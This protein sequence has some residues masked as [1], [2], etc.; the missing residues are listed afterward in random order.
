MS[1][2]SWGDPT[3]CKNP[4]AMSKL[5]QFFVVVVVVALFYGVSHELYTFTFV[6][7]NCFAV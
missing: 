6:I 4:P 1:Y 7:L 5:N 3:R 2:P